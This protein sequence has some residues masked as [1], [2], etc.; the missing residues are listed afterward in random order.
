MKLKIFVFF[1]TILLQKK[2]YSLLEKDFFF[3]GMVVQ[4]H[5]H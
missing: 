2:K 5:L 3:T 1:V 4:L